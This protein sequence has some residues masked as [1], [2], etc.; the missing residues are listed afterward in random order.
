MKIFASL[1]GVCLEPSLVNGK[2]VF[3]ERPDSDSQRE[4]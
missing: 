3:V 2:E 4:S 1:R